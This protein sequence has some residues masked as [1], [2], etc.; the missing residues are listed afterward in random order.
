MPDIVDE[1][2]NAPSCELE[3]ESNNKTYDN[4]V[5]FLRDCKVEGAG[6]FHEYGL[7]QAA[8]WN[9]LPATQARM[10]STFFLV[11]RGGKLRS[12]ICDF[13]WDKMLTQSSWSV[14]CSSRAATLKHSG[15][16]VRTQARVCKKFEDDGLLWCNKPDCDGYRILSVPISGMQK[17]LERYNKLLDGNWNDLLAMPEHK[18]TSTVYQAVI[19]VKPLLTTE[20][21]RVALC[22]ASEHVKPYDKPVAK[23]TMY[24]L[25]KRT[26]Y[27]PETIAAAVEELRKFGI[28]QALGDDHYD[29]LPLHTADNRPKEKI[30]EKS[31]ETLLVYSRTRLLGMLHNSPVWFA[32]TADSAVMHSMYNLM[33]RDF[34][35]RNVVSHD[36]RMHDNNTPMPDRLA[37][38]QEELEWVE[39][40]ELSY[41]C[42]KAVEEACAAQLEDWRICSTHYKGGSCAQLV[43]EILESLEAN[44]MCILT[45][46]RRPIFI[47]ADLIETCKCLHHWEE[48]IQKIKDVR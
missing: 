42:G 44:P 21:I 10:A 12:S 1:K 31:D 14:T 37:L 36:L 22:I 6:L 48:R 4:V 9:V 25:R 47:H 5:S 3:A 45:E 19:N 30:S 27:R 26:G 13:T 16:H 15:I 23:C 24:A 17:L 43:D 8:I 38:I 32:G 34:S 28:L 29:L 41:D 11:E 18:A 46:G 20:A 2:R 7:V 33:L 40:L 39:G 35:R